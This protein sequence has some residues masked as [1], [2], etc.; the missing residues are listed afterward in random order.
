MWT[1]SKGMK[2]NLGNYEQESIEITMNTDEDP[3][4]AILRLN[5]LLYEERDRIK[6]VKNTKEK[7]INADEFKFP[8]QQDAEKNRLADAEAQITNCK[9]LK[10]IQDKK[11]IDFLSKTKKGFKNQDNIDK[12][13]AHYKMKLDELKGA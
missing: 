1:I 4:V 9:T 7:T 2:I 12:L 13:S 8:K 6:G 5:A 10:D 11:L 3:K